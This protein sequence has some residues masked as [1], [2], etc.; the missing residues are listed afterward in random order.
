MDPSTM[1]EASNIV[2]IN[3]IEAERITKESLD[4]SA[5]FVAKLIHDT[6]AVLD[7]VLS[8]LIQE[9]MKEEAR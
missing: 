7:E 4:P 5:R 3:M 8:H 2:R 1:L 9:K 6:N